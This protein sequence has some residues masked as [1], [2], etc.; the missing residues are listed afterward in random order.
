MTALDSPHRQVPGSVTNKPRTDVEACV[1][2]PNKS[3]WSGLRLGEL[4]VCIL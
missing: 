1:V 4:G 2:D 3:I